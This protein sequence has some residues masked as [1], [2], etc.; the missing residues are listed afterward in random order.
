MAKMKKNVTPEVEF[1][2]PARDK[3]D[4]AKIILFDARSPILTK[5]VI[6]S[7]DRE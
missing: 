5:G 4:F 3:G 2:C 1:S 6:A 7:M